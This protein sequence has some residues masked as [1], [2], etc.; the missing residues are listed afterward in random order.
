MRFGA[1]WRL[2]RG[3][4][5]KVNAELLTSAQMRLCAPVDRNKETPLP[6]R[7]YHLLPEETEI[8]SSVLSGR[9]DSSVKKALITQTCGP[10]FDPQNPREKCQALGRQR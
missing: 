3:K 2:L 1:E 4:G 6:R 7:S 8:P 10:E 5:A 9:S